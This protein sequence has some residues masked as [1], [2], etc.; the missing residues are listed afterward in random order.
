MRSKRLR[1]RSEPERADLKARK[2]SLPRRCKF[3]DLP[4]DS[5]RTAPLTPGRCLSAATVFCGCRALRFFT[6]S[7][8]HDQDRTASDA[9]EAVRDAPKE[10]RLEGTAAARAYEDELRVLVVGEISEALCRLADARPALGVDKAGF[11]DDLL[12]QTLG[13]RLL[14]MHLGGEGVWLSRPA[15]GGGGRVRDVSGLGDVG[16]YKPQAEPLGQSRG[17]RKR[18]LGIR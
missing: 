4:G 3:S 18:S 5:P 15:K 13:Y 17:V 16:D 12:E 2:R 8:R 9:D 1:V 6:S 10:R 11:D 14:R 7:P